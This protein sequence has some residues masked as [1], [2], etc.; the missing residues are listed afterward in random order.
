MQNNY[1]HSEITEKIITSFFKVYNRLGYGFLEKVYENALLIELRK[2]R[3]ECLP[4][5]AVKVFY[6]EAQVGYYMADII[7]E[8]LVIIEIKAAEGLCEQHEAQLT[9]YLRATDKEVGMLLNF[10]KKPEFRRKVFSAE[11]KNHISSSSS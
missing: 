3:L 6:E 7:V 11:Y 1:L 4:Q 2:E 9:N 10:G 5:I 8:D